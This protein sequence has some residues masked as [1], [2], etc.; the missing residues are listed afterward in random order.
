MRRRR[1]RQRTHISDLRLRG[2]EKPVGRAS[3]KGIFHARCVAYAAIYIGK[4]QYYKLSRVFGGTGDSTEPP[5]VAR[6]GNGHVLVANNFDSISG[7]VSFHLLTEEDAAAVW[8]LSPRSK[9]PRDDGTKNLNACV[10]VFCSPT[11]QKFCRVRRYRGRKR[12]ALS[13]EQACRTFSRGRRGCCYLCYDIAMSAEDVFIHFA[14]RNFRFAAQF[15]RAHE[16]AERS[17]HHHHVRNTPLSG[18][19][20]FN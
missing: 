15:S 1:R 10:C 18:I 20:S 2:E 8:L 3:S 16:C 13:S 7:I 11:E 6:L 9:F 4:S 14:A 19:G 12:R 17:Q 5:K